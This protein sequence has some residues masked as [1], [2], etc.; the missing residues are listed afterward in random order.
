MNQ[1]QEKPWV[2]EIKDSVEKRRR[3]RDCWIILEVFEGYFP[4]SVSNLRGACTASSRCVQSRTHTH[5]QRD[6]HTQQGFSFRFLCETLPFSL[7]SQISWTEGTQLFEPLQKPFWHA[8]FYTHRYSEQSSQIKAGC[9][10][11]GGWRQGHG[12]LCLPK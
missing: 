5:E 10:V 12:G 8:L 2:G 3:R 9:T 6:M 11:K 4:S 7:Q 1:E